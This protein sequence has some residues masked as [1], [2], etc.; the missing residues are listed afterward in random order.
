[1]GTASR[2]VSVIFRFMELV[3]AAVVAGILGNY[4]HNIHEAGVRNNSRVVYAISIAGIAIFFSLV[5][6]PPLRYSFFAFPLDFAIFVCWMVAFGLLVNLVG[7]RNCNSTWFTTSWSW[8]WGRWYRVPGATV[9][10]FGHSG[11]SDWRAAVAWS[12]IGGIFWLLSSALGVY[13]LT[14]YK[15]SDGNHTTE[16]KRRE[17]SHMASG[18]APNNPHENINRTGA[19]TQDQE[20]AAGLGTSVQNQQDVSCSRCGVPNRLG[21]KFCSHCGSQQPSTSMV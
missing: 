17:E 2:A 15:D 21:N 4:L 14:Q 1:M 19:V 6:M 5:L 10:E 9:A 12:F 20:R 13:V 16:V 3:S 8:A 18:V 7:G 11:C